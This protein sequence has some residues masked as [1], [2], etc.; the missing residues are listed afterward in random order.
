MSRR[1]PFEELEELFDR[2]SRQFDA[3][4]LPSLVGESMAVDVADTGEAFEVAAD[5]PGY[6]REDIDLTITGDELQIE[7]R[8]S[9]AIDEEVEGQYLRRERHERSA[10]RT[11]RIPEPIDEEAAHATYTNGVLRVTLPKA[12]PGDGG[13]QIDIE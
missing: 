9:G 3:G 1:N 12:E 2:M 8:S 4:D 6:D 11:V 5:L 13:R 7:A 10:S